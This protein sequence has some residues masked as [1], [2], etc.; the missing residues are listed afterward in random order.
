MPVARIEKIVGG[1]IVQ[2][3]EPNRDGLYE[4]YPFGSNVSSI[5]FHS[6]DD[7]AAYLRSHPRSGVRMNPNWS[8]I[9]KD[10]FID[11]VPR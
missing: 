3:A 5:K 1:T 7:V 6:L 2:R 4:C 9:S 11:G 10:I 8:K